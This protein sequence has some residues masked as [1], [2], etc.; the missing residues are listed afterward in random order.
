VLRVHA[1]TIA[2]L[3]A[4]LQVRVPIAVPASVLGAYAQVFAQLTRLLGSQLL[5][6]VPHSSVALQASGRHALGGVASPIK[7]SVG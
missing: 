3:F 1:F 5:G 2:H 7:E 6:I 4:A